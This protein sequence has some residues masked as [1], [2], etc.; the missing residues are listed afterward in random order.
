MTSYN[1]HLFQL[2]DAVITP[3][4][5]MLSYSM[6][7]EHWS[8]G[9]GTT[10]TLTID[11]NATAQNVGIDDS[12]G[13]PFGFSDEN[14]DGG[15]YDTTSQALV[16]DLTINGNTYQSGTLLQNEYEADFIDSSGKIFTLVAVSA[17]IPNNGG[18]DY[19]GGYSGEFIGFT[20][21]GPTPPAGETLTY[22]GFYGD[23]STMIMCFVRGTMIETDC[24]PRMI[25]D[26]HVEDLVMT[27]DHG[28]QPIRWLGSR[29]L[30]EEQ[31]RTT[32][33]F[34][35]IRLR[36]GCLGQGRP[37]T[38]LTVSPHHRILV[39]TKIAERM[40]GNRETLIAAKDLCS[41]DGIDLVDGVRQVEYFH[42][43]FD[44]HEIV[45]ANGAET[46]SLFVGPVIMNEL[47]AKARAEILALFPE[48]RHRQATPTPARH[49]VTGRRARKLVYR[50]RRNDKPLLDCALRAAE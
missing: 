2:S 19:S 22:A 47:G 35:P 25:E 14:S 50:H 28:L 29:V 38:D 21:D 36:E 17:S 15:F 1:L 45:W 26:L 32:P 12:D 34:R 3:D 49:L 31:L 11:P 39:R 4:P 9:W 30:T 5:N 24:G 6:T 27:R 44:R 16:S 13:N 43:L 40:F 10:P 37:W 46:E 33:E 8:W 7:G 48:L 20:W 42:M 23:H 41:I 18:T